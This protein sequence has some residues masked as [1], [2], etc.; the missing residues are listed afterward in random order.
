MTSVASGGGANYSVTCSG[1]ISPC[2]NMTGGSTGG[3]FYDSGTVTI[4]V[5]GFAAPVAYGSTSTVASLTSSLASAL[6]ASSSP[7]TATTDGNNIMIA[8]KATGTSVDYSLAVS[9]VSSNP[10]RF[11]P[12]SFNLSASGTNLIGGPGGYSFALVYAPDGDVL[13]AD[14][15]VNGNWTYTYDDFNRLLVSTHV[16][17]GIVYT[18]DYDRYGNRWHQYLNGVCT[19]GTSFCLS[20]DTNN[21]INS[22]AQTFD[23]A[24]NVMADS[25]HHYYYDAENRLI[26]VDGTLGTCTTATACYVYDANGQRVEK[27]ASGISTYFLY[28]LSGRPFAEINSSGAWDRTEVYAGSLHLATYS[29]GATGTTYF[30]HTD[31]LGTERVRTNIAGVIAESCTSLPFGDGMTCAGNDISPLHFTGKER[32]AES[33][34]DNF[35]ARY[36][37]STMGRFMT[38]DPLLNSGQP[39]DPQ[40]WNRYAYARNNPLLNVDPTGLYDLDNTCATDDTKCNKQFNQHAQDLKNG[41][42]NLQKQA[43]KVKDPAQKARLEGALKAFGTQGDNNGVNVSFGAV[44]NGAA[45]TDPV[46]NQQTGQETY[47]V[48]M[49]PSKIGS[50]NDYAVDAAHEGT[51]V[52]DISSELANPSLG[53]LS[54]FS[55]EYRGY[56]TSAFAASA[57]GMGSISFDYNGRSSVIWNG[58]WGAVDRNITNFV[59]RFHDQNGT[60]THPETTPHNP[61]PN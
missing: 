51:H 13:M 9:S 11:T 45:Q 16:G 5:N 8:S 33:G 30:E 12:P 24:G 6:N 39:W 21:R 54:P 19:A 17:S 34:L 20:F 58:S 36:N 31:W 37:A 57:L 18:N 56:Q 41:L 26:Q 52:S 46:Y 22:S 55:L 14:D 50:Q 2:A 47:N 38:P 4:T 3:T 49:D 28:D 61:W 48:T 32:D 40:T 35:G 43:D 44:A 15:S 60:Q 29:G 53:V 10:S 59:T 23:T 1:P 42:A 7:V 27:T 25:M